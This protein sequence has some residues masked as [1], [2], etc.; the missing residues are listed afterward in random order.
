MP[1][2]ESHSF[3]EGNPRVLTSYAQGAYDHG[4]HPTDTEPPGIK[5]LRCLCVQGSETRQSYQR[6]AQL[7]QSSGYELTV[8]GYQGERLVRSAG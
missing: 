4:I 1:I 6:R 2:G 8:I 3:H 7:S 5:Q